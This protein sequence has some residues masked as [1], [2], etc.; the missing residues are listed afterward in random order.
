MAQFLNENG[1]DLVIEDTAAWAD[2]VVGLVEHRITEEDF[3]HAIRPFV[4]ER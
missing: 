2:V 4:M 3:V 1:Y